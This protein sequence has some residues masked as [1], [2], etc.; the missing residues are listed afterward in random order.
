MYKVTRISNQRVATQNDFNNSRPNVEDPNSWWWF[1]NITTDPFVMHM[2]FNTVK[3]RQPNQAFME[4]WGINPITRWST[5][6]P[7]SMAVEEVTNDEDQRNKSLQKKNIGKP[8]EGKQL[9]GMFM[10]QN[11]LEWTKKY[12]KPN[13]LHMGPSI[14]LKNYK[15]KGKE[16]S[17]HFI[18]D[19]HQDAVHGAAWLA[20]H[21]LNREHP[22]DIRV[23]CLKMFNYTMDTQFNE[24]DLRKMKYPDSNIRICFTC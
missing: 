11:N 1:V 24:R 9:Q 21:A 18:K 23:K 6:F 15:I 13:I 3:I 2:L 22:R 7:K 8:V 4:T 14:K 17:R 20:E 10:P 12:Q 5:T 16:P 19:F